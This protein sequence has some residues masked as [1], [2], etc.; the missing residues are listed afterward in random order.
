MQVGDIVEVSGWTGKWAVMAPERTPAIPADRRWHVRQDKRRTS[1]GLTAGEGDLTLIQTPV[2]TVGQSL[3]HNGEA[4][5]VV[6][7]QGATVIVHIERDRQVD[8]GFINLD[9]N[10]PV[11]RGSLVA[12]N[13][14]RL[15]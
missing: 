1:T 7:D 5:T 2:F 3:R 11:D 9:G 14:N 12:E 15:S 13:I 10:T 8:G 6:E 4:C